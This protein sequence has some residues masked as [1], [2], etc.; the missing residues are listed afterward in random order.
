MCVHEQVTEE[1][2]ASHTASIFKRPGSQ[3]AIQ[4]Q[5][6]GRGI[7]RP[8]RVVAVVQS[9]ESRDDADLDVSRRGGHGSMTL[10]VIS[11]P[12]GRA[13]CRSIRT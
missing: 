4:K 3:H 10:A 6:F 13:R 1:S 11:G 5:R 9:P 8:T 12:A 7:Q 2:L